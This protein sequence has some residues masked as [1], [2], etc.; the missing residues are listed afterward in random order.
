[1]K[2]TA[3][4]QLLLATTACLVSGTSNNNNNKPRFSKD[5]QHPLSPLPADNLPNLLDGQPCPNTP[6]ARHCWGN[7]SLLINYYDTTP[8]TNHTVDIWLT[9]LESDCNPDGYRRRCLTFNG[10]VPGPLIEASW[11]DTLIIHVT[12]ALTTN[13]TSIH[14]HGLRQ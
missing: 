3:L 13:G 8:Q 2:P 12:N 7:H 1:M 6:T 4:F 14:W 11:G 5:A 10:T 9:A